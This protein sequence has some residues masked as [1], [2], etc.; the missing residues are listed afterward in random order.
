MRAMRVACFQVSSVDGVS[1]KP[2]FSMACAAVTMPRRVIQSRPS[3]RELTRETV[4]SAFDDLEDHERVGG[5]VAFVEV[6][7][8]AE[9]VEELADL[10]GGHQVPCVS[11]W[12]EAL[13][14]AT[15]LVST[16]M[17]TPSVSGECLVTV[18][19]RGTVIGSSQPGQTTVT[20]P[21]AAIRWRRRA[22]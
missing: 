19:W 11:G 13:C 22:A 7:L 16:L 14:S 4:P 5:E 15:V 20:L 1:V 18:A 8:Y 21:M 17:A 2:L 6:C 10:L 12:A 3:E 9:R